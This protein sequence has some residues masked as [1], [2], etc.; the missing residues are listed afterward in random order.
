MER[1]S[2]WELCGSWAIILNSILYFIAPN[3]VSLKKTFHLSLSDSYHHKRHVEFLSVLDLDFSRDL[4][5][6]HTVFSLDLY[7]R[8]RVYIKIESPFMGVISKWAYTVLGTRWGSIFLL[9]CQLWV[10]IFFFLFKFSI[11]HW[12]KEEGKSWHTATNKIPHS[13]IQ[14]GELLCKTK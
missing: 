8:R 4:S 12:I 6:A 9:C 3:S 11:A 7:F 2:N 1:D 10:I 13:E 14:I 5:A